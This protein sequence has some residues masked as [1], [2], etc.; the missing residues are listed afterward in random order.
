ME[1][2]FFGLVESRGEIVA[3][4]A[5][6]LVIVGGLVLRN[7]GWFLPGKTSAVPDAAIEQLTGQVGKINDR[8]KRVEDD[9]DRLP[10]RQE[11][12]QMHLEMAE[13]KGKITGLEKGLFRTEHAV[14]RIEDHFIRLSGGTVR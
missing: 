11:F 9:V 13:M 10:T 7:V 6:I 5:S 14:G 3:A 1:D 4:V 8:L 2:F 12:H